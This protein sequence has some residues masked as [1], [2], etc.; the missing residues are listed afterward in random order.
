MEMK[1]WRGLW[2]RVPRLRVTLVRP[3]RETNPLAEKVMEELQRA[4]V[5][6]QSSNEILRSSSEALSDALRQIDGLQT[7]LDRFREE[8]LAY[9]LGSMEE[10]AQVVELERLWTRE[11]PQKNV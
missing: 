4:T 5:G 6:W 11:M 7:Q 3:G 10:D 2:Q 8:S 1:R 9:F